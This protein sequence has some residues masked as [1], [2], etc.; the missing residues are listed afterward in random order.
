MRLCRIQ[1]LLRKNISPGRRA[2]SARSDGSAQHAV[3]RVQGVDL[4][5]RQRLAGLLVAGLDPVA[6]VAEH[7]PRPCRLRTG[8]GPS[9]PRPAGAAAAINVERLRQDLQHAGMVARQFVEDGLA[10]DHLA[11]AARPRGAQAEQADVVEHLVAEGVVGVEA[12]L[13]AGDRE[14]RPVATSWPVSRTSYRSVPWTFCGTGRPSAWPTSQYSSVRRRSSKSRSGASTTTNPGPS[15][16]ASTIG[17]RNGRQSRAFL[18][19]IAPRSNPAAETGAV[20]PLRRGTAAAAGREGGG[21][22][23]YRA[24]QACAWVEREH[25]A[26]LRKTRLDGVAHDSMGP[27]GGGERSWS[28]VSGSLNRCVTI[29]LAATRSLRSG[30]AVRTRA[31]LRGLRVAAKRLDRRQENQCDVWHCRVTLEETRYKCSPNVR[32]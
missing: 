15:S 26:G 7:R 23:P 29:R 16:R 17:W 2:N 4:V 21:Q 8:K 6:Q 31:P 9:A 30:A 27:R 10:A 12:A 22:D 20:R 13:G 28:V 25:H 32:I 18:R 3:E 5:R 14:A 1:R 11:H 24:R 19:A